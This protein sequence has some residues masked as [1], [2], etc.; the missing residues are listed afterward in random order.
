[1]PLAAPITSAIFPSSGFVALRPAAI[2]RRSSGQYSIS[3]ASASESDW[4]ASTASAPAIARN[5]A[6]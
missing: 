5:V 3:Q 6:R 1:M 4:N 2:L